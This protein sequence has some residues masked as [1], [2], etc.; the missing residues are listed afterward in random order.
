MTLTINKREKENTTRAPNKTPQW[1]R[2][3]QSKD[4][5]KEQCS[6]DDKEIINNELRI[7]YQE[8]FGIFNKIGDVSSVKQ[9]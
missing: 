2:K 4:P 3:R 8:H 7:K 1:N 5:E 9:V 6:G